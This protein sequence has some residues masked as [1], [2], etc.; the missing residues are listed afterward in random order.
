MVRIGPLEV[1]SSELDLGEV[2]EERSYVHRLRIQN[3][4]GADAEI[5][6]FEVGC[7]SCM[8]VVPE[9]ARIPAGQA[10]TVEL[11]FDLTQRSLR[12]FGSA[13]RPLSNM[14]APVIRG[15]PV[16][17]GSDEKPWTVLGIIKSRVTVD[18]PALDFGES[19]I[20]GQDPIPL[21]L[22][23]TLHESSGN[24]VAQTDSS[25]FS[26]QLTPV[27][28]HP[29]QVDVLITP[30]PDLP[31]GPFEAQ[32]HLELAR[33]DGKHLPA[34]VVTIT[35]SVQ[36]EVRLLPARLVLGARPIGS[37]ADE[38]V[39]I[40]APPGRAVNVAR[41]DIDSPDLQVKPTSVAGIPEGRAFRV[42]Q[43]FTRAGDQRS[44][45]KFHVRE[46]DRPVRVVEMEVA[47]HGEPR[48]PPGKSGNG[49]QNK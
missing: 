16:S 46:A 1:A 31:L 33:Q 17:R 34:A 10:V 7:R 22:R 39:V 23:A 42:I 30:K 20:Q 28:C 13:A 9:S 5:D 6:R 21:R 4:S 48:A 19:L 40:Q 37:E 49:G 41:I 18:S 11:V 36:P 25:R 44:T 26:I 32:L 12:D 38:T 8:K 14:L 27:D 29:Q 47:Y 24:L 43:T 45:A 3:T 15:R 2:W 35:G